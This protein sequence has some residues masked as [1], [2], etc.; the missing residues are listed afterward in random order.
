M[1]ELIQNLNVRAP[2]I[3]R[4]LGLMEA[5][6]AILALLVLAIERLLRQPLPKV[7]YA[8]WLIVLVKCLLP[9]FMPM[10]RAVQLPMTQFELPAI[11]TGVASPQAQTLS[12]ATI[13]LMFW[14]AGSI[15]LGVLALRRFWRL[16]G[17]LRDLQPLAWQEVIESEARHFTWPPIWQTAHLTTPVATGLL[18]PRIYVNSTAATFNREAL[19][20]VLYHE[21]A[22]VRRHD[23]WIV[24]LQT[25][26]QILHPFNPLV[27]LTNIRLSRYREQ[28]CD[29]FALQHVSIP[30]RQYGEMLL[31][32]LEAGAT[33][34][35]K[36]RVGTCFFE[37]ANGF[38]QRLKYL[39]SPKEAD[40]NRFTWKHKVVVV[41]TLVA[42]PIVSWQCNQRLSVPTAPEQAKVSEARPPDFVAFDKAPVVVKHVGPKYPEL[43]IKA[44]IE[45]EVGVKIWVRED[46]KVEAV[47]IQKRSG[48][49]TGFEEAVIE[50]AK[51]FEFEPAMRQGK[52]VAV[53]VAIPFHFSLKDKPALQKSSGSDRASAPIKNK[54]AE[55]VAG[56]IQDV[57]ALPT[58]FVQFDR[59]PQ[60]VHQ[61]T[62]VYPVIAKKAGIEG[63]VW[64]KIL[65][66]ED[67][68]VEK[69][70]VFKST[71]SEMGF[72]EAAI[73]AAQKFE[74]EPAL[75][76]GQPV[77]TWVALPFRFK[78][79]E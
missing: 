37:T 76:N 18:H 27:W 78:L 38:K 52:P 48:T 28:I 8:L 44:G 20:A 68:R 11:L 35:L 79:N 23:G 72:D 77:A 17:K 39:L 61:V 47:E 75:K 21:L 5:Q 26:T 10:P 65:I 13:F 59:A 12:L 14:L 31:R 58:D 50:A 25:L 74:F 49:D 6:I 51:Q 57:D 22:H 40:M 70:E 62:P 45:G 33:S 63:T 66:R 3:L 41:G 29:D 43:A 36:V 64:L 19:Q 34:G 55:S 32:F 73:A 53:W 71:K 46:G 15:I 7:R 4:T 16:R 54:E 60:I 56:H 67:G 30:P 42:L 69:V 2:D 1:A 24:L 9:P